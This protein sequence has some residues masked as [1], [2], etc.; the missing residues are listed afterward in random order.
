[1][2]NVDVRH[3]ES[4]IAV[5]QELNITR[6]AARLHLTQQAVS[7]HIRQLE[8]ALGVTLLVRT[9][10]GVLLTAAGD[11]LA[12]GGKAVVAEL[13]ELVERVRGVARDQIGTLRLACCPY[14]TTLFAVEVAD[15]METAVPG[16][17]VELTTVRTPREELELLAAG[18]AD[19]AFMWLP[20]GDVGLRHAVVRTDGRAVALPTNHPLAGRDRVDLADL[21][22]EPVVRPDVFTSVETE[23]HWIADPRPD[24]TPAPHGPVVAQIEDA[25]LAV[26]RGRGVWFAPAPLA[27]WAPPA[28]V[29]WVPVTDAAPSDLALVWTAAAPEPLIARLVAEVRA[30]LPQPV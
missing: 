19:A 16:L 7:G 15:A 3:V 8:C 26:A 10:R 23:R 28:N 20:V 11:E 1:M 27:R 22:S 13:G 4:F 21:A 29:R 6:A 2:I 5:A 9:H 17:V 24:G 18:S 30:L 14:A 12:A 25:L